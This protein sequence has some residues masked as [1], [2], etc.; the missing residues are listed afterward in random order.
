LH[1][2]SRR[3][4]KATEYAKLSE[5][6]LSQIFN[7][8]APLTQGSLG[9]MCLNGGRSQDSICCGLNHTFNKRKYSAGALNI[10]N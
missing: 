5:Q 6:P 3:D 1:G 8:P 2:K 7:L 10:F 4:C 9:E